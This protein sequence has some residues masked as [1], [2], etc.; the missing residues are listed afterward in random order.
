MSAGPNRIGD[1]EAL[2]RLRALLEG[3]CVTGRSPRSIVDPG[4]AGPGSSGP[5]VLPPSR[6]GEPSPSLRD[7]LGSLSIL[8]AALERVGEGQADS[9]SWKA[10][11]V[12]QAV[13][14]QWVVC[15]PARSLSSVSPSGPDAPPEVHRYYDR[16]EQ[17]LHRL[18]RLPLV[19]GPLLEAPPEP[20]E[21]P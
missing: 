20:G 10:L 4:E 19:P 1:L 13:V 15:L 21:D 11:G 14:E 17:D 12:L 3:L 8:G 9:P 7:V 6:A 5:D 2:A 16:A 18:A